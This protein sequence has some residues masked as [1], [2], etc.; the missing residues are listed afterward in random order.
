MSQINPTLN[1]FAHLSGHADSVASNLR[2]FIKSQK[3]K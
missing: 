1:G 2:G 3:K